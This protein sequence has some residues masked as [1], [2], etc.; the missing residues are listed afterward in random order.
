MWDLLHHRHSVLPKLVFY[1]RFFVN[2]GRPRIGSNQLFI[3]HRSEMDLFAS[4][5]DHG[6]LG[7][8]SEERLWRML[9]S[10]LSEWTG[11]GHFASVMRHN[12]YFA[13]R[14]E[15]ER[16]GSQSTFTTPARLLDHLDS[17]AVSASE[18]DRD[19]EK[20]LV[21]RVEFSA[22]DADEWDQEGRGA[23]PKPNALDFHAYLIDIPSA[24]R[25]RDHPD[26]DDQEPA[27]YVVQSLWEHYDVS[28][29]P[30]S[31]GDLRRHLRFLALFDGRTQM[32]NSER[33]RLT[34]PSFWDV[35]LPRTQGRPRPCSSHHSPLEPYLGSS[36][37]PLLERLE[38]QHDQKPHD[39][40][41]VSVL[42]VFS[43]AAYDSGETKRRLAAYMC[44]ARLADGDGFVG[45]GERTLP[46]G[47]PNL[48]SSAGSPRRA[49]SEV[50]SAVDRV[51]AATEAKQKK[52]GKKN[53]RILPLVG[54]L[55]AP[56]PDT[57]H[58]HRSTP[59][60]DD[61]LLPSVIVKPDHK[62]RGERKG[63]EGGAKQRSRCTLS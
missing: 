49:W 37:D 20:G 15:E 4:G 6:A 27:A 3:V 44:Q 51:H 7:K 32:A 1:I 48:T 23:G 18:E 46:Y 2:A 8:E 41:V 60:S 29:R 38:S 13:S 19:E 56:H 36:L 21:I 34:H 5:G 45:R 39:E 54:Y 25:V 10:R 63:R 40:V 17:A 14:E 33:C 50:L 16:A 42:D 12:L 53:G 22:Y 31:A 9:E 47:L 30:I 58:R 11:C 61:A 59:A 52:A 57:K 26:G 62:R 28:V 43:V 35:P 55:P 24:G